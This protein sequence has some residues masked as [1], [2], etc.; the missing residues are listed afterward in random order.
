MLILGFL[1]P[2]AHQ[3]HT[4]TVSS[5]G[6]HRIDGTRENGLARGGLFFTRASVVLASY[7]DILLARHKYCVTS[8]RMSAWEAS[9]VS[10]GR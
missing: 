4:Y 10:F 7:A 9:V 5:T 2:C 8:Q 1:K 3:V 6:E